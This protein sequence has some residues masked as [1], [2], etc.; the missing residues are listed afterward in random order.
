MKDIDRD[1]CITNLRRDEATREIG[2]THLTHTGQKERK[3][4]RDLMT[5]DQNQHKPTQTMDN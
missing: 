1:I 3:R 2:E 5:R 4:E